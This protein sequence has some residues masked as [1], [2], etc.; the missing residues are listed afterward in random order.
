VTLRVATADVSVVRRCRDVVELRAVAHTSTIDV[1]VIDAN[2]RGLDREMV[3]E[4]GVAQVRCVALTDTASDIDRLA[5]IGVTAFAKADLTGLAEALRGGPSHVEPEYPVRP[6]ADRAADGNLVAVWGP[7]GAPGRTSVAVELAAWFAAAHDTLLVDADT[8]GP[9]VALHLG[10]IDD[11]S[12]FAAAVRSAARG[13]L[14]PDGLAGSAVAV[15][16]GFRVLVGLPSAH[17]WS[18]LRPE[19]VAATL[20]CA[21][22]S[23]AWTVVDVGFGIEGS[24]LHWADPGNPVR[25]GAARSVLAA[26]DVVV[27]VGR[28]DPVGIVR[29]IK[30][31]R[32]VSDLAPAAALLPVVNRVVS[33]AEG[34]AVKDLVST[35][36]AVPDVL[37]LPDDRRAVGSA[38][39]HG[40]TVTEMS[41]R[42]PFAEGIDRLG[43]RVLSA[44]GSYDEPH[45]RDARPHRRLLRRP[46]RGHRHRDARVV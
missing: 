45:G 42:S 9:S 37:V 31:V 12:G 10:L 28:P 38:M 39:A 5:E 2:M 41:P 27:C 32:E 18:E 20:G 43:R 4:L 21:R 25:Y 23:V 16:S 22:S 14:D 35:E 24:D 13:S 40:V 15:P 46:H 30:G 8:V 17:R 1:T 44:V 19:S 3:A 6:L 29:L 26:A 34:R 33:R 36:L 7:T 11:T